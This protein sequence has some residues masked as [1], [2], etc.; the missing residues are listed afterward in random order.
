MGRV[1]E[2][3]RIGRR[4]LTVVDRL[5]EYAVEVV[6]K[7]LSWAAIDERSGEIG[8]FSLVK[9]AVCGT[10]LLAC[11]MTLLCRVHAFK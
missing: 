4:W 6:Q 2:R 5:G 3:Q 11:G 1:R 7:G 9:G 10:I 8:A